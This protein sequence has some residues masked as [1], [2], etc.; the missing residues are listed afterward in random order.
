MWWICQTTLNTNHW[1]RRRLSQTT[2][3]EE[4]IR[5]QW[6]Q[7][8]KIKVPPESQWERTQNKI[9]L[10]Q[11]LMNV[12]TLH[13]QRKKTQWLHQLREDTQLSPRN[14]RTSLQTSTPSKAITPTNSTTTTITPETSSTFTLQTSQPTWTRRKWRESQAP[15]T[16][17]QPSVI[18]MPSKAFAEE[19]EESKSDW[20]KMKTKK[21]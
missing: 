14:F 1:I 8:T 16:L 3:S 9:C 4:P 21:R 17:S 11:H 12:T 19:T 10:D 6:Y 7:R 13:L 2:T 20:T 18:L 5:H 15:S